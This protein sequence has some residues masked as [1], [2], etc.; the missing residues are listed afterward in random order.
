MKAP[1]RARAGPDRGAARSPCAALRCAGAESGGSAE[2]SGGPG[3]EVGRGQVTRGRGGHEEGLGCHRA[4]GK[5]P[6][7]RETVR[8][9][10]GPQERGRL[11]RR[12][13]GAF[14]FFLSR[15][16]TRGAGSSRALRVPPEAGAQTERAE[17][18]REPAPQ[19][20]SLSTAWG[21]AL[22]SIL[23]G[24]L[25]QTLLR[26]R[27]RPLHSHFTADDIETP[28]GGLAQVRRP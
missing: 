7:G 2:G 26:R 12:S 24:D 11:G 9:E 14:F 4:R 1:R 22:A 17:G 13:R 10:A 20:G 5:K 21:T 15:V 25:P 23:V 27:A 3:A 19:P 28:R 8:V 6:E 16:Q 18:I